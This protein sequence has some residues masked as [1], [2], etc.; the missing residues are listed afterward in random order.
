MQGW[1]KDFSIDYLLPFIR[2][3]A[4][5]EELQQEWLDWITRFKHDYRTIGC[6]VD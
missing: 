6:V 4:N 2:P 3:A 1:P 5:Y